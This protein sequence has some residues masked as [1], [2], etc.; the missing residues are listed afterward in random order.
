MGGVSTRLKDRVQRLS[1]RLG[2]PI[3]PAWRLEEFEQTEHL[4]R[5]FK[6]TQIDCVLDVGA[7]IGQ[8]HEFLRL[9]L[10]YEGR[11]VSFEPI[12]EL[13]ERVET[14]ARDDPKWTVNRLALGDVNSSAAINV[15]AERTL[16]SFLERDEQTL[17]SM[18]YAKYLRETELARTEEVPVRRLDGVIDEHVPDPAARIFLKS[19]TQ[20][21]DMNVVRG[22]TGCLD[23]VAALQIELSIRP[24]YKGAPS[25]SEALRE[26]TALGFEITGMFPVQR[27]SQLRVVNFDCVMINSL[28]AASL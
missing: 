8:F 26:L 16:S 6:K 28:L 10:R 5:L 7:N 2:Y 25:Y 24:V 13:Y 22:A 21:F 12:R 1:A 15:F 23:R 17:R 18:G 11:I 20:G 4:E 3:I 9:F 27:D 19:D 14:L